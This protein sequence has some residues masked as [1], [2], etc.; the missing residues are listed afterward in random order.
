MKE[1]F[2]VSPP[3][4]KRQAGLLA[5]TLFSHPFQPCSAE[6]GSVSG[7]L[8]QNNPVLTTPPPLP[9]KNTEKLTP[10]TEKKI[11]EDEGG[12]TVY[13]SEVIVKDVS[14]NAKSDVKH[15]V[16]RYKNKNMTFPAL[17]NLAI[18]ITSLLQKHGERLSYAY[19]PEQ[20]MQNGILIMNVMNGH[21]EAIKINQNSSLVNDKTVN[22]Y[23][24]QM[25]ELKDKIKALETSMSRISDLPG[26]ENLSSFLSVGNEAGGSI[27]ALDLTAAPRLNGTVL[28]DNMGSIS[29]GRSRLGVQLN[30]NSPSGIGDRL[31]ALAYAAPDFLQTNNDSKHG[32]TLIGRLSYDAPVNVKGWRLGAAVSRVSYRLGGPVLHGLGDGFADVASLYSSWTLLRREKRTINLGA[33]FDY[34]RMQDKF[35]GMKNIRHAPILS[36]QLSGDNQGELWDR[37]NILQYQFSPSIGRL[38]NLDDWNGNHTR[39]RFVKLTENATFMQA[40]YPRISFTLNFS[41]QQTSKNLDGAEQMSLGGPYAVRAYSNSAASVDSGWVA[42]PS[43]NLALPWFENASLNLFYDYGKGKIQKFAPSTQKIV[44]KGYGVG[45]NYQLNSWFFINASYAWRQGKDELLGPQ[46]KSTGWI[47]TGINF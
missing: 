12:P 42:S 41:G 37:P 8:L 23:V 39:G 16:D 5:L 9:T 4:I 33:T 46:N 1:R 43:L 22:R 29:S 34:K 24:A 7:Q 21:I 13:I 25:Y 3:F 27:L 14:E 15:L 10:P 28:F 26:V 6:V 18:N 31:Q 44:L 36:L 17:K 2:F 35:W 32:N 40:L 47:T 38:S 30:V 45:L 19:I 11:E 20:K